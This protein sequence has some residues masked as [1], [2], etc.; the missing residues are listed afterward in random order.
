MDYE[1]SLILSLKYASEV[2]AD[3]QDPSKIG[4]ILL[5]MEICH[6]SG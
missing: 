4:P 3:I 2:S 6:F 1:S 5:L